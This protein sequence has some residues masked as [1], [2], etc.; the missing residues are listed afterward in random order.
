MEKA[1]FYEHI[2]GNKRNSVFLVSIVIGVI[3][4]LGYIIGLLFITPAAGVSMAIIIAIIFTLLGYYTGDNLVLSSAGAR[5]AK[6]EEYPY[7]INTVEGLSIASG[8]PAPKIY[9]IDDNAINAFATGRDPE[10][11][12]VAV[13]TGALEKLNRSELE[14]VLGHEMSHINNYDVRF[15]M[16]TT[17]LVGVVVLLADFMM[18]SMFFGGRRDREGGN[19]Q[20]ILIVV[21]LVFAILSPIFMQ[22]IV[23][24]VSR[25]REFLADASGA[26]LTRHPQGLADALKKIKD[27]NTKPSRTANK[28][29]AHMYISNPFK[30]KHLWSTH[31]NVD[32]R[33]KRLEG[34]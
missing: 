15:M 24:A 12:S 27:D 26:M 19:A 2:K 6:K 25:K 3:I 16:L 33:I 22:L 10:H 9:V 1:S 23:F 8:L 18:R 28:A 17:V 20:L 32:E 13:T 30:G 11:A 5:E 21:A 31:P 29:M 7:L 4:F 34:M 14:G